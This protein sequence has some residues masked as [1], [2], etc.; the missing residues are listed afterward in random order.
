MAR[1]KTLNDSKEI[2]SFVEDPTDK[3]HISTKKQKTVKSEGKRPGNGHQ[4]STD[5]FRILIENLPIGICIIDQ[6]K[7]LYENPSLKR[8][9]GHV[10]IRFRKNFLKALDFIHPD[11]VAKV[12]EAYQKISDGRLQK[13]EEDF[14][15]SPLGTKMGD[16]GLLYIRCNANKVNYQG[17]KMILL[18]LVDNSRLKTA[19]QLLQVRVKMSS[20]GQ[21]AAGIAHE[22]RNPLTGINTYLYTLEDL[23]EGE[24]I[25]GD[26]IEL[27]KQIISQFQLAS[28]KIETVIGPNSNFKGTLISDGSVRIDGVCEEGLIKTV[29]NIV[30][31]PEAK[32]AADLEAENVSVSGAVTG[33]INVSGR[34]EIL[35]TGK[36]WGDATVGSFMLDEEG[37]FFK[38]KLSLKNE[39]DQPAFSVLPAAENIVEPDPANQHEADLPPAGD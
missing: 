10:P 16:K 11:D 18:S 15:I 6:N 14:R 37:G 2:F 36:V 35:S 3:P 5:L 26:K 9:M 12:K 22:I 30:V 20:L 25:E 34:L 27:L 32:V 38:G 17:K 7:I 23:C 28:D 24:I 29:G 19:E 39:P 31:G 8:M 33:N 4:E 13:I 21:V 1:E